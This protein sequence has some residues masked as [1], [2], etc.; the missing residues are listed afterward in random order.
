MTDEEILIKITGNDNKIDNLENRVKNIEVEQ[1]Q[2]IGIIRS[3]DKLACNMDSMCEEQRKQ[4]ERLDSLE[5]TPL[6]DYKYYKRMLI[7]CIITGIL[8]AILGSVLSFIL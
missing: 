8:G 4:G 3:V 1:K 7:G 2:I 5:K 6:D